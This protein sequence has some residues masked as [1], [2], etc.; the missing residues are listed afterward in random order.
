MMRQ[1]CFKF[2]VVLFLLFNSV[3][4]GQEKIPQ[5]SSSFYN[6]NRI[7]NKVNQLTIKVEGSQLQ[8]VPEGKWLMV[9]PLTNSFY[10]SHLGFF[11]KKEMQVEKILSV[12]VKFRLGSMDYVN[13]LEQKP[14]AKLPGQ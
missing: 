8:A 7:D 4:W 6:N 1:R 10:C 14:N 13:Y 5:F 12:P 11:C 2:L 3:S 9:Q